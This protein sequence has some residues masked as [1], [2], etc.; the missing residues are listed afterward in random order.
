M[1]T[2]KNQSQINVKKELYKYLSFWKLFV[3]S[4]LICFTAT[5]FY[6]KYKSPVY[7]SQ[8]KI[9]IL[10]D[11][12]NINLPPDFNSLFNNTSYIKLI[13]EIANLKSKRIIN[14]VVKDLNL[15]TKYYTKGKIRNVELWNVPIKVTIVENQDSI[16]PATSFNIKILNYGYKIS[17]DTTSFIVKGENVK[18]KLGNQEFLI[19]KNPNFFKKNDKK[20]FFV[21]VTNST[22]VT[23]NLIKNLVIEPYDKQSDILCISLQD[24][25]IEKTNAT[26]NKIVE[27]LNED[28]I[29]DRQ[30]VSK[31]TI[32]FIDDRFN[33]LIDELNN[34]E[35]KK[36]EYKQKNKLSF[37]EEDA[38][39]DV[40]KKFQTKDQVLAIETQI[41]LLNLLKDALF[42]NDKFELLPSNIGID[43]S[44]L[45][46][47]VKQYNDL[48][49]QRGNLLKT[50]CL[51]NELCI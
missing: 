31:R 40:Q 35:N 11:G 51:F 48:I 9:K 41:E 2:Q 22:Y 7:F 26:I 13:N 25:N 20:E 27:K 36:K 1:K 14:S 38:V 47:L 15:T 10:N 12:N 6:I 37:I 50:P 5:F 32:E 39:I 46:E 49:Y 45:N 17:N 28:G 43:N 3:I 4:I 30:S 23:E 16:F 24:V 33:Y 34:I 21:K 42:N 8:S 19:D 44:N 29:K 18:I